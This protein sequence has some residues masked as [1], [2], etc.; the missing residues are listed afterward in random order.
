MSYMGEL[1]FFLGLQVKQKK[2][3]IF[4]SQDKYVA[5]IL[6]KFGLTE[7]KSASTPI[8]TEKP[9]LKDPDGEDIDVHTYMSMIVKRIFRYLKGKPHL[10]LWY[11]KDSPF[12]LVAYSDSDYAGA[13]LDKKSTTEGCQFLGCKLISWQCKKQ[14]VVATSSIEAEYVAAA[15]CCAQVLWIQNQ[16][17]D[18][19]YIK[20]ALTVNPDIYVSCIKQFWNTIVIKQV[21]DVMRLQALVN[22]KKVVITEAA[23]REVLRL[24]DAEGLGKKCRQHLEVLHVSS[25]YSV[26][27]QKTSRCPFNP[28][29]KIYFPC[30]DPEGDDI[31]AY[32]EVLTVSQEPSIPSPTPPTP[33][34]QPPQDLPSTSQVHHTPPQSPQRVDTSE[35][36]VMDDASNQG[37]IT[38]KMDKDDAVALMDDKEEGKRE[39]EAKEVVDVVTTAKLITEV[40]TAAIETITAASTNIY[41]AEPQ[42]PAVTI[43]VALIRVADAST[44]RRNGV[45]IR[46]PEEE[47]TTSSVI[48]AD[49]KS[50]DKAIDHVKQKAKEDSTVQRYQV[51][52]RKPQT[53][54]QARKNMIMYLKNVDKRTY[55]RGIEQSINETLAQKVAKR[56]KLNEEVEDLKR[57]LEIVPDEDVDVYTEATPLSRKALWNLVKER[58]STSKPKNFSDD[59]LLTTIGAMFEKPDGQAQ[60][61]K[62]QRYPLLRFTLEQMLNA[63]RLRVKEESEISLELLSFEVDAAMDLEEKHYV[64]NAAGEELSAAKQSC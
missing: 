16:L 51:M 57:H 59:F 41:A 38:D 46:D 35:D 42:V 3:G 25:F 40:V 6:R 5:E 23:I 49:T 64:F 63:V 61:W 32:G 36:T 20:Y 17:L 54:A 13:S 53:E 56:R 7:G 29:H 21:N 11:L 44:R 30:S 37:R 15:S 26:D 31:A 58:F 47:S 8:D 24:D 27:H 4:I 34:P 28:H 19:G 39:E 9:L 48:P 10:G 14:T 52:K 33:P 22:K 50:K 45:V 60:V 1:T 18:Y 62:N 43:T 55:G 2:D 12:D